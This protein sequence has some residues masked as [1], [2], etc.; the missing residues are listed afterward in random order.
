MKRWGWLVAGLLVVV[1]NTVALIGV[2]RN[3]AG[4]PE[5]E[6]TLTERELPMAVR[7]SDNTGMALRLNWERPTWRDD[8]MD[9]RMLEALGFDCSVPLDAASAEFHYGKQLSRRAYVVLEYEGEAWAEWLAE[10][11][12]QIEETA[13][14]EERGELQPGATGERRRQL[15]REKKTRSRL[16]AIDAAADPAG[17]RRQYPDRSRF[18]IAPGIARPWVTHS[19]DR[20]TERRGPPELK[21]RI[22]ELL[23]RL[24]HVGRRHRGPFEALDAE[25]TPPPG[26]RGEPGEPHA[27]RYSATLAF[28]QRYEPWI[29]EVES[30]KAAD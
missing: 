11:E 4:E 23:V 9:R 19:P 30:L 29:R 5:A 26:I 24:I 12:R 18:V 1:A 7:P 8:W 6:V 21:G 15:E 28:G 13:E 22:A 27:P 20:E 2:A 10:Q 16:I 14:K 3:R 25:P 17:L